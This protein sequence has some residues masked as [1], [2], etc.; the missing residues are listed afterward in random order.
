MELNPSSLSL[1]SFVPVVVSP[2]MSSISSVPSSRHTRHVVTKSILVTG[3]TSAA[4]LSECSSPGNFLLLCR[5][6]GLESSVT[7]GTGGRDYRNQP[8]HR[9]TNRAGHTFQAKVFCRLLLHCV[10][11]S[12][13][14]VFVHNCSAQE[15]RPLEFVGHFG[16]L[17]YFVCCSRLLLSFP[18]VN[19]G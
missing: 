17:E 13:R 19:P 7:F 9:R 15:D 10:G 8:C 1:P 5:F 2:S 18:V 6:R 11:C 4:L 3:S 14:K 12:P 16:P